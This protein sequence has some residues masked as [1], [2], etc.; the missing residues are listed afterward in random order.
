MPSILHQKWHQ[1]TTPSRVSLM[2]VHRKNRRQAPNAHLQAN[3]GV[4]DEW[5]RK[6]HYVLFAVPPLDPDPERVDTDQDVVTVGRKEHDDTTW[7]RLPPS[8]WSTFLISTFRVL[9]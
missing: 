8:K 1:S 6:V 9:W 2:F 7:P 3:K 5:K 4:S